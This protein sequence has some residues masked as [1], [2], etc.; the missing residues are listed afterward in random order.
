[1]YH[2]LE[3][4]I[5][6]RKAAFFQAAHIFATQIRS[7]FVYFLGITYHSGMHTVGLCK[8]MLLVPTVSLRVYELVRSRNNRK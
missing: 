8:W 6:I 1:M 7:I 4:Q 3:K 2:L 5:H